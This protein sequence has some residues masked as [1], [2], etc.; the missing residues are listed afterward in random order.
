MCVCPVTAAT[1]VAGSKSTSAKQ[2]ASAKKKKT[3]A[4]KTAASGSSASKKKNTA[5]TK[6]SG[7]KPAAGSSADMKHRHEAARREIKLT[8]EQIRRNEA[9]VKKNLD[10]LGK[11]Q[12]DIDVSKKKVADASAKVTALQAK[13][14]GLQARV[15]S[16]EKQLARLRAEYLKAVKAMRARKGGK[17]MLA[18]IFS[19]DSFNEAVRRM[20]YLKQF[21]SWRDKQSKEISG[22]VASLKKQTHEL[23]RTKTMHDRQLSV[24]VK[25]RDDLQ[26]QFSRQDAVVADLKKNGR[27]LRSHLAKKQAEANTLKNQ[28]AAL[29]AEETR[30]A[31]AERAAREREELL[32]R[33]KAEAA[34]KARL[35]AEQERIT[36]QERIAEQQRIAEQNR[37]AEQAEADRKARGKA[38][39][40]AGSSKSKAEL[41]KKEPAKPKPGAPKPKA[42]APKSSGKKPKA[43]NKTSDAQTSYAE[44]RRRRPKAGSNAASV[45]TPVKPEASR[46]SK[47]SSSASSKSSTTAAKAGSSFESMRGS[48]PRPVD[49]SFRVTSRFGRQSL[50]DMPDVSYDN[51]GIDAE[52]SAGAR[53]LAVYPGRVSGV[54]MVPGYSTVVIVNHGSYYTVYGHLS[55]ASVKPGDDV[56]QGQSLGRVAPDDDDPSVGSIHFEVWRNRDKQNPLSWIR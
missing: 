4:R 56:R 43:E 38:L 17:S 31:E 15:S 47:P 26:T 25:A 1:Q 14:N 23:A 34:E 55:Q 27:A 20:R 45:P 28:V 44:A 6:K 52:V 36:E 2:T 29:I 42:E 37:R 7:A 53:A 30:K 22:R 19:S 3:K 39:A 8:E 24:E 54:Y 46:S 5:K 33:Q 9:D 50:P 18:F 13:I 32:A 41:K 16:E 11:I 10:M 12:G 49:G 40:D 35:K 51:P 48:L 21:S